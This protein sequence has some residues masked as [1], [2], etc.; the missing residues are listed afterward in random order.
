MKK[1]IITLML[2]YSILSMAQLKAGRVFAGGEFGIGNIYVGATSNQDL[3][4]KFK[5]NIGFMV[6]DKVGL[7][8]N[9]GYSSIPN[10]TLG[11]VS[12]SLKYS[13]FSGGIAVPIFIPMSE[14]FAFYISPAFDLLSIK[15]TREP[16]PSQFSN[17]G[18]VSSSFSKTFLQM[19]LGVSP[20]ILYF[21]HKNV[22]L[23]FTLG[24]FVNFVYNFDV[25]V[26]QFDLLNL[27]SNR[28]TLG[29]NFW[30]GRVE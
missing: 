21:P 19:N 9:F 30:F 28:P 5:P 3:T 11:R 27:S 6:T 29:V 16:A 8:F 23:N 22:G 13:I 18:F 25:S 15:E 26:G 2:G 12:L 24:S 1:A 10:P 17:G 20:G 4:I 14:K 7:Q